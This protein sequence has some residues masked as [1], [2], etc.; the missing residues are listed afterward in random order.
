MLFSEPIP[1]H[2]YGPRVLGF[3]SLRKNKNRSGRQ[4]KPVI[5]P[6]LKHRENA[7]ALDTVGTTVIMQITIVEHPEFDLSF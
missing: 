7:A 2:R 3:L 1:G 4:V 5:E 6:E